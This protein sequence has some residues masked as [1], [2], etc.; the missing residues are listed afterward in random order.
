MPPATG[1][2]APTGNVEFRDGTTLLATLPLRTGNPSTVSLLTSL[3]A[4]GAHVLTATYLG[5]PNY[6]SATSNSVTL[7]VTAHGPEDSGVGRVGA[8]ATVAVYGRR[9]QNADTSNVSD[10]LAAANGQSVRFA[11]RAD[12]SLWGWGVNGLGQ[13]G[14]GSTLVTTR[15]RS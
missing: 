15:C 14:D 3:L 6:S 1:G 13:L 12:R 5:D 8:G 7:T 4:P 10:V 11:I 2:S 9:V